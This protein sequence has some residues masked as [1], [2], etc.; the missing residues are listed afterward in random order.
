MKLLDTNVFVYAKGVAHPY[1]D[2]CRAILTQTEREPGEFGVDAELL[3]EL[4]DLYARRGDRAIAVRAVS[5]AL[6]LVP[7]PFPI[8]RED[9]EEATDLFKA[10]RGLSPRDALHAAIVFNYGLEGIVSADKSFDRVASLT[11][12]DPLKLAKQ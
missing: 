8:A 6:A 5:E 7:E 9:V 2:A 10:Y 11:R 1:R 12:F 3:Q 4:L